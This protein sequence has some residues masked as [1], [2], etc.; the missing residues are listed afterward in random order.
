[1]LRYT[2][3]QGVPIYDMVFATDHPAG[4]AIIKSVYNS[5]A[6]RFQGDREGA[7]ARRRDRREQDTAQQGMFTHEE[8]QVPGDDSAVRYQHVAPTPPYTGF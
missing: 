8:L 7:R 5:A 2:N 1:M 6:K 3:V 4:D